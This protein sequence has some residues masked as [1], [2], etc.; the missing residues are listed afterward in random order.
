MYITARERQILDKLLASNEEITVK[1]LADFIDVSVRTIHRDLKGVEDILK[2]YQLSLVK[3]SG[4]GIQ[5]VGGKEQ[6]EHLKLFLFNLIHHE[7]SPEER[8]TIIAC[9]LLEAREPVKLIA[10]AQDLNVTIATISND[11]NKVEE[12]LQKYKSLS[13][14]RKRGYGVEIAGEETAKRKAM[15]TIISENVDEFDLLSLIRENIQKKSTTQ[16]DSISERLLGLVEK[17]NLHIVEKVIEEINREL[18]YSIADSAYMGLVVHLALAMERILQGENIAI[19]QAYLE[20]LQ[21]TPEFKIAEKIIGKLEKVFHTEIPKAEIGYITMHLRGAKLR[22]DKEYLIEDTSLQIALKAKSLIQYVEKRT[23]QSLRENQS[24]LQGLVAHLSPAIFRI[25]QNMGITNP[26]LAKIKNDYEELFSI[27]KDGVQVILTDLEVPDEE[28]GY[29]V[30]HFGSV[31]LGKSRQNTLKAL[32]VCSSGIGTS[33]ML[34]TRLQRELPSIKEVR[35]VSLFELYR[36]NKADYDLI[37]STIRIPELEHEYILVNPILTDEEV[38]KIKRYLTQHP[39]QDEENNAD[40]TEEDFI[41][42]SFSKKEHTLNRL[43]LNKDYVDTVVTLLEGFTVVQ[44]K[45]E[46]SLNAILTQACARLYEQKIIADVKTVIADL[47]AREQ[48]GGLGIPDTKLALYHARSQAVLKPSFTVIALSEPISI[49][50]MDQSNLLVETI[51]LMLSP[52]EVSTATLE[53]LSQISA[54]IIEDEFSLLRFESKDE[55][56]ISSYLATKLEK[57]IEE[58]TIELRSV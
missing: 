54:L 50:A 9:T 45:E 18:P 27:V 38:D 31:L 40:S 3:K 11:L 1:D 56:R 24:L 33:K 39:K 37:L 22:Y 26:L 8:Q 7:Y 36:M 19:D 23:G 42:E 17:R 51:L 25:K 52:N 34:A 35:N 12:Q 30:L 44:S 48:V 28:I 49:K 58:K 4:V 14:I 57:F 53:I 43:K 20:K 15:S 46:K 55:G 29:L 41:V 5:I 32:V 13:L 6:V 47:R 10:L 2:G 21:V 16:M